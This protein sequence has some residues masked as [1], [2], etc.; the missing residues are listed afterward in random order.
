MRAGISVV[1]FYLGIVW[2][3]RHILEGKTRRPSDS[4]SEPLQ[5]KSLSTIVSRGCLVRKAYY[6]KD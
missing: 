6:E 3:G 1:F 4:G 5:F 2:R